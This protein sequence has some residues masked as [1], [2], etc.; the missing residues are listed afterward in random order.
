M[1]TNVD[2]TVM[3]C[4]CFA[5]GCFVAYTAKSSVWETARIP[6]LARLCVHHTRDRSL[7]L[8][9]ISNL[10]FLPMLL[11]TQSIFQASFSGWNCLWWCS[12]DSWVK[13][14]KSCPHDETKRLT[15]EH[16]CK[17][18]SSYILTCRS[19][20]RRLN[21]VDDYFFCSSFRLF[22]MNLAYYNNLACNEHANCWTIGCQ[23]FHNRDNHPWCLSTIDQLGYLCYL[24]I[25][26]L[27]KLG[28]LFTHSLGNLVVYLVHN[29]TLS[30][31]FCV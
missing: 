8:L 24:W 2:F 21:N 14:Q 18:T 3:F 1:G 17:K 26:S 28:R 19:W 23:W 16:P 5:Q 15:T 12:R 13:Q 7:C 20:S 29:T 30:V 31:V 25:T 22:P 6:C 10:V 27:L 11:V 4:F 9:V